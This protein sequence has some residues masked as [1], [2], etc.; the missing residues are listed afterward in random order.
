M[1]TRKAK[2]RKCKSCDEPFYLSTAEDENEFCTQRCQ[3][4]HSVKSQAVVKTSA[5]RFIEKQSVARAI[6]GRRAQ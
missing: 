5:D 2:V 4:R 3:D 1:Q 6:V